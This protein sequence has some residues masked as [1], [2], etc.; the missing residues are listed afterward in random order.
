[1]FDLDTW[2]EIFNT[3]SKNVTRTLL[4]G[5]SVA[6]GIFMLMILLG[7]GN[8]MEN[9]FKK[10][11]EE[12]ASNGIW[13]HSGETS[14]PYDGLQAGREIQFTNTDYQNLGTSVS[15][16]EYISAELWVG[17]WGGATVQYEKEQG[18]YSLRGVTPD[19]KF[20]EFREITEGRFINETDM[21]KLRKIAIIGEA[22]KDELFGDDSPLGQYIYIN[23]IPFV[24]AGVFKEDLQQNQ[25]SRIFMPLTTA[26]KVFGRGNEVD[27]I[28]FTLKADNVEDS[29]A[30]ID[31]IKRKMAFTHRFHPDDPRA[32]YIENNFENLETFS[33]IF[34]GISAFIW[35]IG[36]G[37]IIAG[38]V[39]VGN[40]MTV[41]VKE[42]TKEIGVRKALGA[43]PWSIVSQILMEALV[44]TSFFGIC[45]LIF[46]IF[47][48]EGI[49]GTMTENNGMFYNPTVNFGVAIASTIVIVTSG[50]L[51]GLF[52]AIKAASIKPIEA[53]RDE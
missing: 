7:V 10:N 16:I 49:A 2:Q 36:I 42:R 14:I 23:N 24:V 8:G 5:L 12:D 29:K 20:I 27:E 40:I 45:G 25:R 4:T 28:M 6:W 51:A 18:V 52:P 30:I 31:K 50:T 11:F 35:V 26:Q 15:E 33:T 3:I 39:G 48:M 53:L 21:D 37:T 32:L 1:M 38:I 46:G 34:G 9:G 47:S 19:Q 13:L 41:I 22:A 44:I 17:G 43:T